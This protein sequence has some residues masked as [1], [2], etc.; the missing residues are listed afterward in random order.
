MITKCGNSREDIKRYIGAVEGKFKSRYNNFRTLDVKR[1]IQLNI[2]LKSGKLKTKGP[3]T[4]SNGK[5]FFPKLDPKLM[6][7]KCE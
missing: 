5:S 3:S 2:Q 7:P 4:T 6:S 1:D